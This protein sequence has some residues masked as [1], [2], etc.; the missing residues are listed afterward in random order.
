MKSLVWL[1][2]AV[3]IATAAAAFSIVGGTSVSVNN[4]SNDANC[5]A[6]YKLDNGAI[7]TDSKSTNTL[8][9]VNTVVNSTNKMQGDA[10]ADFETSKSEQLTRTD[11]NLATGFPYKNGES[12]TS[13]SAAMWLRME[14]GAAD[15]VLVG[16]HDSEAYSFL[17][18]ISS[19]NYASLRIGYD[20]GATEEI[21]LT[22]GT[23]L[24]TLTWYHATFSYNG[25]TKA[26]TIRI[27]NAS[28]VTV[29]SDSSGTS[30]NAAS[31]D[32]GTLRIGGLTSTNYFDGLLDEVVI[33]ND[34]IS[35]SESLAICRGQYQ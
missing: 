21:V 11:T 12:N 17:F 26:A 16:K 34:I 14:S 31:V 29:G 18:V 2:G 8:T 10:S 24:S 20:S 7:T 13:V 19:S 25:S 33:F 23:A 1:I 9:N 35:E 15:D 3:L 28:C 5:V 30:T 22:H 32:T 27:K 6:W 4:F